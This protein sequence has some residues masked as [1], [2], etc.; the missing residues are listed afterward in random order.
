MFAALVALFGKLG[1]ENV[2]STLATTIRAGVMFFFL[3]SF[4]LATGKLNLNLNTRFWVFIMLSGVAGALSWL[5][6]FMAIENWKCFNSRCNR[7]AEHRK[8]GGYNKDFDWGITDCCWS[9][10][11]F[12]EVK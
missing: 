2:D 11:G 4:S 6:Y 9:N 7:Q 5:F 1:L 8:R 3:L 10:Y 12:N